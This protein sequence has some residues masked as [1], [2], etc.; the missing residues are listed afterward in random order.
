[1]VSNFTDFIAKTSSRK[2]ILFEMDYGELTTKWYNYRSGIWA[3]K[4]TTHFNTAD[5][6]FNS[7]GHGRWGHGTWGHAG[8]QEVGVDNKYWNLASCKVAGIQQTLASTIESCV[9][10]DSSYYYDYTD[11]TLYL[12]C[13]DYTEPQTHTVIV[14]LQR[15]F[16]NRAIT[17]PKA[18]VDIDRGDCESTTPPMIFDETAPVLYNATFDRDIAEAHGGTYSYK[19]TKATAVG[20]WGIVSLCDNNNTTDM[21]GFV[22]GETYTLW[23]WVKVPA[24]SGIALDEVYMQITDYDSGWED[25]TA[26]FPTMFDTWQKISITR[27]I[28]SGATGVIIRIA[29]KSTAEDTEYYFV[30]DI[31]ILSSY[32]F[33]ESKIDGGVTISKTKDSMTYGIMSF[34]G[35]NLT[36]TNQGGYFDSLFDSY[37]F[38]QPAKILFGGDDL[39][40]GDYRTM[41][42]GYIGNI[43]LDEDKVE[44]S[45]IDDRKALSKQIPPNVFDSTTYPDI[46]AKNIGKPIPLCWG[47]CL[48]VTCIC[49]NEGDPS[50]ANYTFV[51]ADVADHASGITAI[52]TAYVAGE[53][54]V[55]ASSSV[56]SGTFNI[57]TDNYNPGQA[58]TADVRGFSSAS[59]IDN[60]SLDVIEDINDTY[61]NKT[62]NA[63]T[64]N[65]TTWAAEKAS[66]YNI[67]LFIDKKTKI[68]DVIAEIAK[69]NVANFLIEDDGLYSWLKYDSTAAATYTVEKYEVGDRLNPTHDSEDYLTSVSVGYSKDYAKRSYARYLDESQET[70]IYA[71]YN[72]YQHQDYDTLLTNVTNAQAV[73]EALM[74]YMK[75]PRMRI[76][77][78]VGV[79]YM[80]KDIGNIANLNGDRPVKAWMGSI[81]CEIIGIYK[82]LSDSPKV[83]LVGREV[84]S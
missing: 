73:A 10:L 26:S 23:R 76:T 38:G 54:V 25:T 62:Y 4:L 1:M 52:D 75:D 78:T 49:T 48:N 84:P 56:L 72:H 68:R 40:Y 74:D 20:S 43:V 50:A 51:V 35:G 41:F 63:S 36:L 13:V 53:S 59:A 67:G 70:D 71:L 81:K 30:D 29:L 17:M 80:E 31:V 14:G 5:T 77:N 21:H 24:A 79:G 58:T 65:T 27:T 82:E 16:S 15:G 66:A 64:Y 83:V 44:I 45:V 57:S 19:L 2:T 9:V 47:T 22:A 39:A 42:Q 33:Y 18:Y 55:I 6:T 61:A 69:S 8:A 34:D 7:W 28:R 60:N 11:D 3:K 46:K 37:I 12:H 32:K